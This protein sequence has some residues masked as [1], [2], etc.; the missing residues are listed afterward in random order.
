M[1]ALALLT[2]VVLDN[3]KFPAFG[4]I[5]TLTLPDGSKRGGQ[6]L[7]V[8]GKKAI[9]QVRLMLRPSPSWFMLYAHLLNVY[10]GL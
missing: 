8:V 3:V 2:Q 1:C 10:I 6:V 5:V 4:E 9:V 7:E